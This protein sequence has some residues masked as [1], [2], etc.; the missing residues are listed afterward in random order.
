MDSFTFDLDD[1]LQSVHFHDN[2]LRQI[3]SAKHAIQQVT[4]FY[5]AHTFHTKLSKIKYLYL[6]WQPIPESYCVT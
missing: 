2:D 5:K 3:K 6:A 1:I 4:L